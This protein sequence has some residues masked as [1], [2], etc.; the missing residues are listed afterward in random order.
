LLTKFAKT[1]NSSRFYTNIYDPIK[2]YLEIAA[3]YERII[4]RESYKIIKRNFI[5][6]SLL[7]Y[8][9]YKMN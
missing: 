7:L 6:H 4:R 2:V 9:Q 3:T 1:F 8:L 5:V